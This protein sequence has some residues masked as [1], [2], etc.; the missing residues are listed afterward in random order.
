MSWT[1]VINKLRFRVHGAGTELDIS[2][3]TRVTS[4]TFASDRH[5]AHG[6]I[7]SIAN[8]FLRVSS[9]FSPLLRC[10]HPPP[11]PAPSIS[12][13]VWDQKSP[14]S[15]RIVLCRCDVLGVPYRP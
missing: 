1:S 8:V 2:Y 13:P 6:G 10:L 12:V 3:H 4:L 15:K 7:S 5:N 14:S 11:L 9:H